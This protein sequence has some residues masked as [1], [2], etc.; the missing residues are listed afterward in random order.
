MNNIKKTEESRSNTCGS[1]TPKE[2]A[3]VAATFAVEKYGKIIEKL[4]KE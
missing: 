1:L 4:A 3:Q 2:A